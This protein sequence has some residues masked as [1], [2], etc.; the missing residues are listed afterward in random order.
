VSQGPIAVTVAAALLAS[1]CYSTYRV[2]P[3]ELPKINGSSTTQT[4]GGYVSSTNAHGGRTTMAVATSERTVRHLLAPD[5]SVVEVKGEVT[6]DVGWR[7][8][9]YHLEHPLVANI[10][11]GILELH[12]G[13]GLLRAPVSEIE[14]AEVESYNVARTYELI[15][16]LGLGVCVLAL[17]LM[18]AH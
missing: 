16:G 6:A 4:G 10:E 17:A 13:N 14:Y 18:P 5:E 3:S 9:R 7:G 2:K 11:D 8:Q 1:G 12:G 15:G